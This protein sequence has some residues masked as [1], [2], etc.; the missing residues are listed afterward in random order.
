MDNFLSRLAESRTTLWLIDVDNICI[1]PG[2]DTLTE[3]IAIR[4]N[5]RESACQRFTVTKPGPQEWTGS[6]TNQ[7]GPYSPHQL[8]SELHT[9]YIT[10]KR[11][12]RCSLSGNAQFRISQYQIRKAYPHTSSFILSSV[13][14]WGDWTSNWAHECA[15]R[16][17]TCWNLPSQLC[18]IS[19]WVTTF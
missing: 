3:F 2:A 10:V 15:L 9:R 13:P 12:C 19:K 6:Q 18:V 17:Y 8:I 11:L 1:R 16:K 4:A 14:I 7:W 5:A